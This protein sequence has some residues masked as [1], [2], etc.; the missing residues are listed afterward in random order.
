MVKHFHGWIHPA[1]GE[2][3]KRGE[4]QSEREA[5]LERNR[6]SA[7][8]DTR[9]MLR[10]AHPFASAPLARY[11]TAFRRDEANERTPERN[12]LFAMVKACEEDAC[13]SHV[14]GSKKTANS[15][16]TRLKRSCP[17]SPREAKNGTPLGRK[18][19]S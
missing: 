18:P 13:E 17:E 14:C 1:K 16:N 9:K 8:P 4:T 19:K 12:P 10:L 3:R 15:V 5:R 2:R 11:Y 7:I 6:A